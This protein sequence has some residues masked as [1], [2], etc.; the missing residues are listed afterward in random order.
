MTEADA[1]TNYL[2]E[3]G[4]LL[5]RNC[6]SGRLTETSKD[7]AGEGSLYVR[8]HSYRDELIALKN[9]N[10]NGISLRDSAKVS[11]SNN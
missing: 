7:Y 10:F 1:E 9:Q 6:R 5:R 8:Q 4:S 2:G 3:P 11:R